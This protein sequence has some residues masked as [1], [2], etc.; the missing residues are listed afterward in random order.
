MPAGLLTIALGVALQVGQP[1]PSE[2]PNFPALR[3]SNVPYGN[4]GEFEQR[5]PFDT[6]QNWVHG[7]FQEIPAYGGH[8]FYRPYNYKDVLSQSQTAAGWGAAPQ[9]PY[10][11]QFW[12]RYHDQATMLKLSQHAPVPQHAYPVSTPPVDPWAAAYAPLPQ[13]PQSYP[14]APVAGQAWNPEFSAPPTGGQLTVPAGFQGQPYA[15]NM[16]GYVVPAQPYGAP[17][18][19]QPPRAPQSTGPVLQPY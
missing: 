7:Y 10:S 3:N 4:E 19:P 15:P 17:V 5:Y 14:T 13:P 8:V 9:L 18:M 1:A 11:Q 12:H 16:Q 2:M 6:Q